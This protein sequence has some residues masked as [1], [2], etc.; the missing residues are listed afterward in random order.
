VLTLDRF[1]EIWAVDFEFHQPSGE[2]PGVICMVAH[3][4][5]SGR[6]FLMWRDQLKGLRRPPYGIGSD[7]LFIAYYASAEMNCHLSLGWGLPTHVIDLYVEFRCQV[8]GLPSPFDEKA[9]Y[10]L[11]QAL[12]WCGLES[13]G[14]EEKEA[15]RNLAMR[16][17]TFSEEERRALL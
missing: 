6:S 13:I 1:G 4:I 11:L 3:E 7:S 15:M 2:R 17:G 9:R 5:R 16:G 10:G 12:K 14:F 8:N